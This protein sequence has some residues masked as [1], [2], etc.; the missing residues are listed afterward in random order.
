ME[1]VRETADMLFKHFSDGLPNYT[2][3]SNFLDKY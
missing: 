3:Q 1:G 2:L